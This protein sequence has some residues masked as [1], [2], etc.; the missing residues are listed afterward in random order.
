MKIELRCFETCSGID[1]YGSI[2]SD[3]PY[4][5]ILQKTKKGL[6]L[7]ELRSYNKMNGRLITSRPSETYLLN[8]IHDFLNL[9]TNEDMKQYILETV[10]E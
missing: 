2:D 4:T 1:V 8:A 7:R 6:S 5:G 9:C 3:K 10:G